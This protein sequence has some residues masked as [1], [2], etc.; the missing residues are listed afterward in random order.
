MPYSITTKDGITINNIPD[1]VPPDSP[2]LKERVARIRAG[3]TGKPQ[4]SQEAAKAEQTPGA[5]N[6]QG[7]GYDQRVVNQSTAAV[8]QES[9]S[10]LSM[11]TERAVGMGSPVQRL[12]GGLFVKPVIGANQLVANALA[13]ASDLIQQ[14]QGNNYGGEGPLRS[15]ANRANALAQQYAQEEKEGQAR[16]VT[17]IKDLPFN[18]LYSPG[19]YVS[20][21]FGYPLEIGGEGA[22]FLGIAGSMG[23][24]VNRLISPTA[25]APTL[26]GRV[27]T[28][29]AQ[30][31]AAAGLSPSENAGSKAEE[32][33]WGGALGAAF[34]LAGKILSSGKNLVSDLVS[35]L[36]AGG[37]EKVIRDKFLELIPENMRGQFVQSLKEAKE[38]VPGSKPTVAEALADIPESTAIAARQ[39]RL[40]RAEEAGISAKFASRKAEQE[41]A[42]AAALAVDETAV[43]MYEALR[44]ANAANNYGSAFAKSVSVTP[45][46]A[47]MMRDN[48]FLVEASKSAT[49]KAEAFTANRGQRPSLTQFLHWTKQSLDD[50]ISSADTDPSLKASLVETKKKLVDWVKVANPEYDKARKE[51]AKA[52][53]PLNEMQIG[54]Y[55]SQKLRSP[56]DDKERAAA[57]ALAIQQA[58]LTIK[59][60]SDGEAVATTLADV[61]TPKQVAVV[62]N[63]LA[64]LE[65]K[66]LAVANAKNTRV[67]QANLDE[68]PGLPNLLNRTATIINTVLSAAKS[69]ANE[70]LNARMAELLLDPQQLAVFLQA[71]PKKQAKNIATIL[72]PRLTPENQKALLQAT[73]IS[74]AYETAEQLAKEE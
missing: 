21:L 68:A 20:E 46:L 28:G 7:Q 70:Q 59:K 27:T 1:D 48:P 50:R 14:L 25:Q 52:S 57:F 30:G 13:G 23:S 19:A 36:S 11:A 69:N 10:S 39:A 60:A 43:P 33:L 26:A 65:R 72:Y 51:F 22:N 66:S 37:R 32:M 16:N 6:V 17:R 74:G 12:T 44:S 3:D 45:K 49:M 24:P 38:I 40:S 34:P 42:R 35:P 47:V 2:M 55:L 4:Q 67:G 71:V 58:P 29:A 31:V 53:K 18:P 8:P 54:S 73:N 56:L 15:Y 9:P 63:V 41:A 61:L 5:S 64:D 62:N